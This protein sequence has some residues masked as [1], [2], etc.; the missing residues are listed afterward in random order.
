MSFVP[1]FLNRLFGSHRFSDTPGFSLKTA[2]NLSAWLGLLALLTGLL[3][4]PARA[5]N[6]VEADMIDSAARRGSASAQVLLAVI[7]LNGMAGHTRDEARAARW[8]ERAAQQGND[9]AQKMLADLYASGRGVPQ[10]LRLAA[11][12]REKAAKRGNAQAQ[13]LLG[14]MYLEGAGVQP[15]PARARYWLNRAATEG[16]NADAQTLLSKM[17]AEGKGSTLPAPTDNL[18][19]QSAERGYADAAQLAQMLEAFGYKLKESLYQRPPDLEKLARDGDVDAQYQ[20]GL[21]YEA[22]THDL[23]QDSGKALAWFRQAAQG[24]HPMA[25]QSLALSYRNGLNGVAVDPKAARYWNEKAASQARVLSGALLHGTSSGGKASPQGGG[26]YDA[27]GNDAVSL[28]VS[29]LMLAAYQIF[30]W[31]KVRLDPTFTVQAVNTLARTLWV[32]TIMK[33]E[34]KGVLAIQTLRNST[35]AATF[36]ASTAVLL[37]IGVLTLSGQGD[38]LNNTWHALN[39]LGAKHAGV[40]IGKLLFLLVDFIIAFFSFA[41]SVRIYNHVGYMINVPLAVNHRL[42][43]PVLVATHLNSGGRFYSIGMRAYYYSVPLVFW[44]FG[45]HLMLI[46]TAVLIVFLYHLD[47]APQPLPEDYIAD[48]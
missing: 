17:Q 46:S 12:W 35:M 41:M 40:W 43:S 18:L 13:Y 48:N 4:A 15:D 26:L 27:L 37:I 8:F 28:V 2:R 39:S 11:D 24:G 47:R 32:D 44:L 42:I 7:Y 45:P 5:M 38:K 14:K 6:A 22:G 25:M 36:L 3:S 16:D 19:A 9:Y 29:A 10:N 21:R 30:L 33:D 23:P 31:R 1:F 20:L 34:D